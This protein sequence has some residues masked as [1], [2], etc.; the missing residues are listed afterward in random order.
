MSLS[1]LLD[2]AQDAIFALSSCLPCGPTTS[3]LKLNGRTFS[4]VKLLGEGGFSFVYLVKDV[5][6]G[7][8]FALKKIR[9]SYGSSS[10]REAIK[11]VEATKRF[12]CQNVIQVLDSCV[13]QDHAAERSGLGNIPAAEGG[14]EGGKVIYIFLPFYERGN[15]QDAIAAHVVRGTRFGER[16]MLLLFQGTC[17]GVRAMHKYRLPDVG[18]KRN[19]SAGS[20]AAPSMEPPRDVEGQQDPFSDD[21]HAE[22]PLIDGQEVEEEGAGSYPPRPSAGGGGGSGGNGKGKARETALDGQGGDADD[23]GQGGEPIPYAHRDIKPGNVMISDDGRTPVLMDFGSTIKARVRITS[24]REA[25]AHQ[26]YAAERSSMPYR[27]P[28]L[29]D[30]PTDCTLTEAVDIWSLGC[31]LFALAYLHSPFETT[32]TIEQ[33]G[34]IALAV[35]NGSYKFPPAAEDPYSDAT[36]EIIRRCIKVKPDERP[37]IDEVLALTATALRGLE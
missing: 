36:R 4:I 28:E 29:F 2:R 18:A 23:E 13:V 19:R 34:S 21:N 24:R 10:F 27:A 22:R 30:V 17:Q 37:D 35:L 11:E 26:D 9:C 7:R 32:Q 3:N 25:V 14:E 16:E 8:I 6:S 31:M 12:R 15:L 1:A 33:G 20:T 5:D